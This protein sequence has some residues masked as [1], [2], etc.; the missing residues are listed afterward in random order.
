MP[1]MDKNHKNL[2]F[3]AVRNPQNRSKSRENLQFCA[4]RNLQNRPKSPYFR[5]FGG[6]W[7]AQNGQK[8]RKSTILRF[9]ESAKEAKKPLFCAILH[10]FSKPKM[11]KNHENLQF[12]AVRNPQNRPKSPYFCHFVG[13][14]EAQNGQK[15]RKLRCAESAKRVKKPLHWPILKDSGKPKIVKNHE[16][17]QFCAFRNPQNRPKKPFKNHENLQ[18]CAVRN[19]QNRPKSPYFGHFG[20]FWEK[21]KMVKNHENLQFSAFRNLQKRPKNPYLRH[22]A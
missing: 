10:D 7:E 15:S 12:C 9:P 1:K 19:P 2:Q 17:L 4:F 5:H 11:V 13:F 18:F 22:F 21:P 6:F 3:C 14:L 16:N 20:G 8:S